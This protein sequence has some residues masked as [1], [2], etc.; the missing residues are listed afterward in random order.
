MRIILQRV[1]SASVSVDSEI[2]ASIGK[3]YLAYLG[4]GRSDTA[5]DCQ[6]LIDKLLNLRIFPNSDHKLDYSINDVNGSI[7]VVSQFTLYGDCKKGRRPSFEH[8]A[9]LADARELYTTFCNQ[10][11]EQ[12]SSVQ[13]GV[14]QATMAVRSTNDGPF[15]LLLES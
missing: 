15:T 9:P 5:G 11:K 2:V 1:K 6:K 8:A 13:T 7:L 12:Y 4:I 10:L 14:F 3:G